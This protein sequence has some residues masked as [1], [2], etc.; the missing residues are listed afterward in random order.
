MKGEKWATRLSIA[1]LFLGFSF[2]PPMTWGADVP[3]MT[4]E[5]LKTMLGNPE[6][7]IIDVRSPED[8]KSSQEKIQGAV[9]EDPDKKTKSWAGKYSPDKMMVLYCA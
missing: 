1:V 9:R 8:W 4:K 7:S 6:V 3:R 2:G 5:E